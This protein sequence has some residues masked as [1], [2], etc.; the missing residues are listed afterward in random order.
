MTG[1]LLKT[2]AAAAFACLLLL[3]AHT[4][5]AQQNYSL[6]SLADSAQQHLP[7]LLQKQALVNSARANET[8]ARHDFL[9]SL[10]AGEEISIGSANDVEG[11]YAPFPGL[12]RTISGSIRG[13][14]NYQAQ[15]GNLVSLYAQYDLVTFGLR[16]A[17]L[18]NAK[19]YTNAAQADLERQRYLVKLQ[20]GKLYFDILKTRYQLA[21]DS[22]NINRYQSVYNI[23]TAL[24][25]SGVKAGVDSS[26][27]KAE[28]SKSR[29]SYNERAGL[30]KRQQTQLA[31]ITGIPVEALLV[32]TTEKKQ[33]VALA[34]S[35][36]NT[37]DTTQNPLLGYY[38]Q[39]TAL[40]AATE[41][42]VKKSYLPHI[43]LGGGGW[44]RG[45]S[46]EYNDK[47][48]SLETGLGYQRF[49]YAAGIGITYN[50]FNGVH[51]KDKLAVNHFQS[52]AA[53]QA[54]E[55]EKLQLNSAAAQAQADIETATLN[56]AELPVQL[57]AATD[58][59]Q[60]KKAQY[61]AGM[62]NLVDL[63]NAGYVLYTAQLNYVEALNA[64]YTAN[65]EKSA[66]TG[67][68]DLFIQ[69]LKN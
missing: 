24:T 65:L 29:V 2:T 48:K 5:Y 46:I 8:V 66:A 35:L 68:L 40:Y 37:S 9:P 32:D 14:N 67:H 51:R 36:N 45:S 57:Q 39:Q 33:S 7:V 52:L 20:V 41:N 27:A 19:A 62:I 44:A 28:L 10:T 25:H 50:L 23:I 15:S 55:Q 22:Q 56:L 34:G 6:A 49:N 61:K 11:V 63:S 21:V 31:Y 69:S 47:Y 43:M 54:L 18:N 16:A 17:Q 3:L 59:F 60:Q 38:A 58:A 26:L 53:S 42:L 4:S 64:W 1:Y 30:L 13:S 12:F